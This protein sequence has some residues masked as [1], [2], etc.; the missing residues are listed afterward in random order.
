MSGFSS[1]VSRLST[2]ANCPVPPIAARTALV[3]VVTSCPA[4]TGPSP[5]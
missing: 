4:T 5:D 1:P 2:E 3:A